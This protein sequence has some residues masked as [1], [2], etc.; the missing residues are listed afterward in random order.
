MVKTYE[1]ADILSAVR[2]WRSTPQGKRAEGNT[3]RYG[4]S[5]TVK[6]LLSLAT[7][8]D[9]HNNGK[10]PLARSLH[11]WIKYVPPKGSE[12]AKVVYDTGN[13]KSRDKWEQGFLDDVLA[14][15]DEK[16]ISEWNET[17]K[18]NEAL[19][20]EID[21]VCAYYENQGGYFATIRNHWR[22]TRTITQNDYERLCGNK[23]ASKVLVALKA[24]PVFAVGSIVDFRSKKESYA[25]EGGRR[26]IHK[27][28][29]NGLL[30]LSNTAQ[31]VSACNGAKRY[32]VVAVGDTEP[33]Y[34]E[35]RYIKKKRLNKK[36]K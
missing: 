34:T 6:F 1:I 9:A 24:D 13:Y 12:T 7:V 31:I 27:N 4:T 3:R 30:V 28:A 32:K 20:A 5:F 14:K 2:A 26:R 29:P 10:V 36:K 21:A 18:S 19:I 8:A 33:F 22:E 16:A 23:Y 11:K 15:Y 17:L 35:E 25:D